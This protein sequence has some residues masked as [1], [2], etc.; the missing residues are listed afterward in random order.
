MTPEH[1]F[2][3]SFAGG[4]MGVIAFEAVQAG[5][6]TNRINF[7]ARSRARRALVT[8]LLAGG[9]LHVCK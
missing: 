9:T 4:V 6:R 2:L 8:A 7:R 1:V 5:R 3:I